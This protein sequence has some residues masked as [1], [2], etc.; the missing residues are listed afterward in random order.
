MGISKPRI[1]DMTEEEVQIILTAANIPALLSKDSTCL[2][3][4]LNI[5]IDVPV[6]TFLAKNA[7]FLLHLSVNEKPQISRLCSGI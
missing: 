2:R 4:A 7:S 5:Y 3:A 1:H 6:K